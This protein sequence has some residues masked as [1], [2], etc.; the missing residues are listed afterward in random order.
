MTRVVEVL[1]VPTLRGCHS[2]ACRP[3]C[4]T[5]YPD[6]RQSHLM[7]ALVSCCQFYFY[8]HLVGERGVTGV[9]LQL[10]NCGYLKNGTV[11]YPKNHNM[12]RDR[13]VI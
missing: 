3:F 9:Q 1:R 13:S 10:Q 11:E 2:F 7:V 8:I 5:T 12:V 6:P 4:T